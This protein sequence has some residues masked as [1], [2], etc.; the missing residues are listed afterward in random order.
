MG[1]G[2]QLHNITYYGIPINSDN[3]NCPIMAPPSQPTAPS[4]VAPVEIPVP[5]PAVPVPSPPTPD[6]IPSPPT[7]DT[8]PSPPTPVGV[9][10][11][12]TPSC[13]AGSNMVET[14]DHGLIRMADLQIGDY[15]VSGNGQYTQVYGFG[16]YDPNHYETFVQ[17]E[18][19]ESS[20]SELMYISPKHLVLVTRDNHQMDWIRAMDVVIGDVLSGGTV[21]AL[22]HKLQQGVYNPLTQSGDI[23]VDGIVASNYVD[24][25]D[26][27]HPW[28]VSLQHPMG[29]ALISPQRWFCHYYIGICQKEG[30]IHGY[31]YWTYAIVSTN[32][33][34]QHGGMLAKNSIIGLLVFALLLWIWRRVQC[35]WVK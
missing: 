9:P 1:T 7:P 2:F 20:R 8:I 28:V 15:V 34:L 5:N 3:A 11:P 31:G 35:C 21:T 18:L 30:Y 19:N 16:H 32:S 12:P 24:I 13:F 25:L 27:D 4:I 10:V 22:Y 33:M 17:I 6:T 29:H 23:V 26:W 14:K